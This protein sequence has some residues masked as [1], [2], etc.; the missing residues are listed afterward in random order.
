M[1][2]VYR[3]PPIATPTTLLLPLTTN[4]RN[5]HLQQTLRGTT[6]TSPPPPQPQ[7]Q[8]PP[9]PQPAAAHTGTETPLPKYITIYIYIYIYIKKEKRGVRV[10]AVGPVGPWPWPPTNDTPL[11]L[12]HTMTDRP[13]DRLQRSDFIFGPKLGHSP[14]FVPE[15]RSDE[16]SHLTPELVVL[17]LLLFVEITA[18]HVGTSG[19]SSVSVYLYLYNWIARRGGMSLQPTP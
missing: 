17:L 11:P 18:D 8:Q 2:R 14:K 3:V 6:N 7:P 9:R 16:F 5:K 12:P 19:G 13:T 4:E 1:K 15:R 10:G